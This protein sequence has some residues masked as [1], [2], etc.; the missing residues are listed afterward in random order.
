MVGWDEARILE[1][2]SNSRC[3]KYDKLANMACLINP[4]SQPSFQNILTLAHL[5]RICWLHLCITI[6]SCILLVTSTSTLFSLRLHPGQPP[7]QYLILIPPIAPHSLIIP[8]SDIVF[9]VTQLLNKQLKKAYNS[10]LVFSFM[11]A[12]LSLITLEEPLK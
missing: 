7:Y 12:F 10:Y 2:E 9:I 11:A 3:R 5:Q 8:S 1:I 4:I 6:L